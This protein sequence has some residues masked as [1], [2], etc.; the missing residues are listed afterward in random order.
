M[1]LGVFG[2]TLAAYT[3]YLDTGFAATDS[4][5]LVESSRLTGIDDA[6]RLFAGPV[7]AGTRFVVVEIVYRPFVS[8]S[9]GLD[10]LV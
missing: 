10:H 3:R 7:M 4:L 6:L 2:L 9:F 8:L 5:P 1:G